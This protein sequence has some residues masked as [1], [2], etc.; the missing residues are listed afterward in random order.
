MKN[1][2]FVK[3]AMLTFVALLISASIYGIKKE[4]CLP[5]DV[6]CEE[7]APGPFAFSYPIDEG[8][9]CPKDF[10]VYGEFL[11]IKPSEE[12]LEYA[13]RQNQTVDSSPFTYQFPLLGG[14]IKGF[15]RGSNEWDWKPGFRVGFGSLNLQD[16]WNVSIEWTYI[17]IKADSTA[18]NMGSGVLLPL[19]FPRTEQSG[20]EPEDLDMALASSRWSG[21]YNTIDIMLGKPY[22]VSRYF[23]SNPMFGIRAAF[24]DQDYHIRYFFSVNNSVP[25]KLGVISKNNAFLKNDYWGVGLKGLYKAQF[26]I[27]S[28]WSIYSKT[29]FSLLFG[30][31]DI[32]QNSQ[33]APW[34]ENGQR[35]FTYAVEDSFYTV[36]PN[37][38]L[39]LGFSWRKYFNHNQQKVSLNV[40]YE[41]H[42]WW[43]QNQT[44]K[45]FDHDPVATDTVSRGDLSFNGFVFGLNVDF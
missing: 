38:E 44:R 12:G 4:P 10:Y 36:L 37:A 17:R 35:F 16:F 29:C 22:H 8:F 7:L 31:F 33:L 14:E 42:H 18:S 24:I 5:K 13:I 27:S 2:S 34:S 25:V 3:K 41:F 21:D 45:F 20:G 11:W 40:G 43:N 9:A 28:N 1:Y 23:I 19:Y 15:S 39:D 30:K 32:S 26:R 6:C